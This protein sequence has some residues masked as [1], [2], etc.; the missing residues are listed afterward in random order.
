M[1]NASRRYASQISAGA[2]C[3]GTASVSYEFRFGMKDTSFGKP[4]SWHLN[5]F[6]P[7]PRSSL[8]RFLRPR[9]DQR[10]IVNDLDARILAAEAGDLRGSS[11]AR[12]LPGQKG[13]AQE[14]LDRDEAVEGAIDLATKRFIRQL[15]LLISFL[16]ML[17]AGVELAASLRWDNASNAPRRIIVLLFAPRALACGFGA[18]KVGWMPHWSLL[19]LRFA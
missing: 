2:E 9:R 17:S 14:P 19:T 15:I 10:P 5:P 7:S 6:L 3:I 16:A 18:T 8:S 12:Q 11:S 4:R 13:V 1:R